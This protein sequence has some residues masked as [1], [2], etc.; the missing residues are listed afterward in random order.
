MPGSIVSNVYKI[1]G[2]S[3]SGPEKDQLALEEALEIKLELFE[4]Q[5]G[6]SSELRDLSLTMRTPGD[7]VDLAT[8]FLFSEGIISNRD[9]I[10]A[11]HQDGNEITISLQAGL[12]VD[13]RL[14]ARN[15]VSNS[16]CGVCGKTSLDA[17]NLCRE[18]R[19][20]SDPVEVDAAVLY[21]LPDTVR[22]QQTLFE[23]TGGIHAAAL[24]DPDGKMLAVREDIGRH[25]A[26][27]KLIGAVLGKVDFGGKILMVSGRAG[28][29]LV[30]KAL[31][32]HIPIMAA[33]G[34]PSS[35]AVSMAEESGMTLIGFL[36]DGRF[37]IYSRADRIKGVHGL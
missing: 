36:R 21:T 22:S 26:V 35:L 20:G 34:A 1:V 2:S 28:F 5:R 15:F 10:A 19:V 23:G 9:Q 3:A 4:A 25:N 33:I 14:L 29:E 27:D 11:I 32:A 24:F 6:S 30:Q 37:N 17:V 13:S 7:D 8:G 18:I 12:M 16:G 31:A